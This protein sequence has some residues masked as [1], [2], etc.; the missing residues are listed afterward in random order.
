MFSVEYSDGV[1]GPPRVWLGNM[2][3]PGLAMSRYGMEKTPLSHNP[4]PNKR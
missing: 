4:R 3:M 2:D 1:D